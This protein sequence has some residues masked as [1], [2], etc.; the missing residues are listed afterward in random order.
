MQPKETP[1]IAVSSESL[2]KIGDKI[3]N[4]KS[5]ELKSASKATLQ[6]ETSAIEES[7]AENLVVSKNE[8]VNQLSKQSVKGKAEELVVPNLS[9]DTKKP[10]EVPLIEKSIKSDTNTE[11]NLQLHDVTRKIQNLSSS[12]LIRQLTQETL[13]APT[14][15]LTEEPKQENL[16]KEK[17]T[18]DLTSLA[19]NKKS[20]LEKEQTTEDN[21]TIHIQETTDISKIEASSNK[22]EDIKSSNIQPELEHSELTFENKEKLGSNRG[23][24]LKTEEIASIQLQIT[25]DSL[26]GSQEFDE[27]TVKQDLVDSQSN[28][29]SDSKISEKDSQGRGDVVISEVPKT[30]ESSNQD[31]IEAETAKSSPPKEHD[32]KSTDNLN[33]K[34]QR[35]RR[36][37][38]TAKSTVEETAIKGISSDSLKELIPEIEETSPTTTK[39]SNSESS[40]SLSNTS[41]NQ[42]VA[43]P[44]KRDI[45][46][47]RKSIPNEE[48]VDTSK[49]VLSQ[50]ETATE[51]LFERTSQDQENKPE[52][53]VIKAPS[54]AQNPPSNIVFITNLVRPFTLLQLKDVLGKTGKII[55]E[56]FW[57]D[58]IKSKCY[59]SYETVEEAVATR[60][61]LHGQRWPAS[62]PK[63]LNVDFATKEDLEFQLDIEKGFKSSQPRYEANNAKYD[64]VINKG[65]D[66][67]EVRERIENNENDKRDRPVREWDRAKLTKNDSSDQKSPTRKRQRSETPD[68]ERKKKGLSPL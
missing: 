24:E 36:W 32:A 59:T 48:V 21:K 37:G 29:S 44:Q 18:E 2:E 3:D 5:N 9:Q 19:D 58:K 47:V 22:D 25:K 15:L 52:E 20:N 8:S 6:T 56:Q 7:Q 31:N 53:N 11:E 38:S 43:V 61:A 17:K 67:R 39:V 40:K 26:E 50:S 54:P 65:K 33:S 51:P 42:T 49:E 23:V 55:E 12:P 45:K 60:E 10:S 30:M 13:Q 35:K 57:I 68:K 64:I 41:S 28:E 66:T 46:V 4:N 14:S 62:N 1:E 34:P 63:L 27:K 16:A